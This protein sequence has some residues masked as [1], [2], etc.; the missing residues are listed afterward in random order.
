[1]QRMMDRLLDWSRAGAANEEAA[2]EGGAVVALRVPAAP[3]R[4]QVEEPEGSG[5]AKYRT[6]CRACIA[7]HGLADAYVGAVRDEDAFAL[8]AVAI[9]Y[10]Y[11]SE[12]QGEDAD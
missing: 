8:P 10:A 11:S 1:M 7:G 12:A 5:L 6:W 2:A 4:D 3:T 9:N